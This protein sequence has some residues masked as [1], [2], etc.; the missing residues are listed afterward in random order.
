MI[1]NETRC[2]ECFE[3][4]E[5]IVGVDQA[6]IVVVGRVSRCVDG[7]DL[8]GGDIGAC[9]ERAVGPFDAERV[10]GCRAGEPGVDFD[11]RGGRVAC[12]A[13]HGQELG[14]VSGDDLDHGADAMGCERIACG[15]IE[16]DAD[17]VSV[18]GC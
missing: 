13:V 9:G 12:A 17:P 18:S 3:E 10:D 14:L 1:G 15:G 2:G 8:V 4:A 16:L 6:V 7:E 11:R 5:H